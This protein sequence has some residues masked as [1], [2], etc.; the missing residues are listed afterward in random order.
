M[1]PIG[2]SCTHGLLTKI[3]FVQMINDRL[4]NLGVGCK[5]AGVFMGAMGFLDDLLLLAPT[6]YA[7]QIMLGTSKR[8]AAK[9]NLMFSTDPNP[10]KSKTKS[11]F[12]CG[13]CTTGYVVGQVM[14]RICGNTLR[15]MLD[16]R[17][18]ADLFH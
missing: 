7:M 12:E 13:R 2:K 14:V 6:R 18:D 16:A 4:R 1:H 3:G 10:D 11:I 17:V 8:F 5:V 15:G 9:Y